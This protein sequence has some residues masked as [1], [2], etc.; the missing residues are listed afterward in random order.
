MGERGEARV[1]GGGGT[2]VLV[3]ACG[4][5]PSATA[6]A[7]RK[8][9]KK[10][11]RQGMEKE[12]RDDRAACGGGRGGVPW[13]KIGTEVPPLQEARGGGVAAAPAPAATHPPPP[14]PL[15]IYFYMFSSLTACQLCL[16]SSYR[17][18]RPQAAANH[19]SRWAGGGCGGGGCE[20]RSSMGGGGEGSLCPTARGWAGGR[21]GAQ[22]PFLTM[23]SL[24]VA[25]AVS[26]T[27]PPPAPPGGR[28]A[29]QPGGQS[30]GSGPLP[31]SVPS[32][33][34][35]GWGGGGGVPPRLAVAGGSCRPVAGQC[36]WEAVLRG[37][38]PEDR[39]RR[40]PR[41]DTPTS[42][43]CKKKK[44]RSTGGGEGRRVGTR[45]GAHAHPPLPA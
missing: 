40:R 7:K 3:R 35:D 12:D 16:D 44:K 22:P 1:G 38:P 4:G 13:V 25:D 20:E 21:G 19:A 17:V 5:V 39:R 2:V 18:L 43:E 37:V 30:T 6:R 14:P 8:R 29:P 9:I 24:A 26:R 45:G 28:R 33:V 32:D 41:R 11:K 31:P 36:V 42:R 27:G 10:K 23:R 15:I 34:P